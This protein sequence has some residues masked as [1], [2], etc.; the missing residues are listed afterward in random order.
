MVIYEVNLTINNEIF[1]D[2]YPW[3]I[4]HIEIMLQFPGFC[5]AE[6]S[7]EKISADVTNITKMAIHYFIETEQDL[8]HYLK[9]HA[10]AM[11]EEGIKKFGDNFSASRRI[12]L[13]TSTMEAKPSFNAT[14]PER[15]LDLVSICE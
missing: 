8:N 4:K 1:N 13:Q 3:L 11:R 12:F 14:V 2:Y 7:K 9:T 5:K 6:I 15:N 10:T